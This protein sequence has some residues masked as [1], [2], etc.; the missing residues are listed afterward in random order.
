MKTQKLTTKNV[1]E[2]TSAMA[3]VLILFLVPSPGKASELAPLSITMEGYDYPYKVHF[4]PLTIGGQ[5]LRMAYMDVP[6]EGT[7]N[8]KAVLLLHG[9]NFFGA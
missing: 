4:L 2:A 6:L 9:K 7:G 3:L 5:D 8:G 1:R